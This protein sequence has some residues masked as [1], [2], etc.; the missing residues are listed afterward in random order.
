LANNQVIKSRDLRS[1]AEII[2]RA[3]C[4]D[5]RKAYDKTNQSF[6]NQISETKS[7]KAKLECELAE[8]LINYFFAVN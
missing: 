6:E 5:V 7:A 2:L 3:V 1:Q 8:V 4:E